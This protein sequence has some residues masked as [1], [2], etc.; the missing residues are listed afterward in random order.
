[1]PLALTPHGAIVA[2]RRTPIFIIVR[3]IVTGAKRRGLNLDR[4]YNT[5]KCKPLSKISEVR[6]PV[7]RSS[8]RFG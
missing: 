7:Q 1:M 5:V 8:R 3:D 4:C 6:K 2:Y